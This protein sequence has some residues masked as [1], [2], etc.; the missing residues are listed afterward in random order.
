MLRNG[1]AGQLLPETAFARGGGGFQKVGIRIVFFKHGVGITRGQQAAADVGI[2]TNQHDA[3]GCIADQLQA[4][5][6][7]LGE[8]A[9]NL[10]AFVL[11]GHGGS[12]QRALP[13]NILFL[14]LMFVS[15]DLFDKIA[16]NFGKLVGMA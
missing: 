11:F 15:D 10:P 4:L 12:C 16:V 6:G 9:V 1:F 8:M 14:W 3:F 7:V 13:D 2:G 5:V